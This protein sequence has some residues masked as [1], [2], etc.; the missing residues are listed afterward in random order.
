MDDVDL[1]VV[2]AGPAGAVAALTAA[3]TGLSVSLHDRATFPRDKTCGDG[4]TVDALRRLER[5]GLEPASVAGWE[6]VRDAVLHSPSG[7]E[8]PLPL[9]AGGQFLA[10]AP[11]INLDAAVLD[12]ARAAG[13][14][15]HEGSPLESVGHEADA[16]VARFS[17]GGP[18]RARWVV[19]ADGAFSPV[20]RALTPGRRAELGRFH[21]FRQYFSGV[22][23]RRLHVVFE[24]DVLPG[25]FWVFPLPGGRANVGF[26]V[27]RAPGV[28]TR[29]LAALWR[30]LVTRPR[31]RTILGGA[32]ADGRHTAWPIPAGLAPGDLAFGRVLF[33]G[34]AA[35]VGDPMTG[36]GIAQALATGEA[37]ARAVA[38]ALHAHG[39]DNPTRVRASY[40]AAVEAEL[41][42]DHRFAHALGRLLRT[43]P[44]ARACVA[45]A[46]L[47]DW[48]RRNFA[49]WLFE[50]YPRA[51]ILTPRRWHRGMFAGPGAYR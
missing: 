4:L 17:G 49:R 34:D 21:A 42:A 2:G 8:V 11:R 26:G 9:P 20:R 16:V 28:P 24:P 38:G 44:G 37:A 13:A 10:V 39:G 30:D 45:A 22:D 32:V 35:A 7:R 12:L 15:V 14:K 5:I 50:D 3:R 33:A 40:A 27:V 31:I 19:A 1:L 51:L 46:G 23:D 47:T 36:E 6:P 48:T 25:Y 29:Y 18:V 41:G 43:P